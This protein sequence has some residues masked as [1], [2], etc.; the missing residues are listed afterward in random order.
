MPRPRHLIEPVPLEALV[1]ERHCRLAHDH[2]RLKIRRIRNLVRQPIPTEPPVKIHR[3]LRVVAVRR[4]GSVVEN[5]EQLRFRP[6]RLHVHVQDK[7]RHNERHS[8]QVRCTAPL[9]QPSKA[10]REAVEA[11]HLRRHHVHV[12]HH[13]KF[14]PRQRNRSVAQRVEWNG[15]ARGERE[16]RDENPRV[17]EARAVSDVVLGEGELFRGSDENSGDDRAADVVLEESL[18]TR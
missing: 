16:E 11:H 10:A 1:E 4:P 6:R 18:E 12:Q 2:V 17:A 14:R 7:H 13:Y 3:L 5:T 15:G 9:D 8:V